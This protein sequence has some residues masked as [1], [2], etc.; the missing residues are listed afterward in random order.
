MYTPLKN[1][2][3]SLIT[4]LDANY[5]NFFLFDYFFF[6]NTMNVSFFR[7]EKLLFLVKLRELVSLR[8]L[9]KLA[10]MKLHTFHK[11]HVN[12]VR[13]LSYKNVILIS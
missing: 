3:V 12:L 7:I 10:N 9:L 5:V 13:T 2:I 6:G 8:F 4:I 1:S 11:L